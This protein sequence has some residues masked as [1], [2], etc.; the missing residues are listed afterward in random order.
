MTEHEKSTL[1]SRVPYE[2]PAPAV[3]YAEPVLSNS[4]V[5]TSIMISKQSHGLHLL[6][7]QSVD[8]SELDDGQQDEK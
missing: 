7:I 8:D 4:F 1:V 2:P 5:L 6:K 3:K